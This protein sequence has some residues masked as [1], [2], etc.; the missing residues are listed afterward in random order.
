MHDVRDIVVLARD[1]AMSTTYKPALLRAIV[2]LQRDAGRLELGLVEVAEQFAHLYWTQTVVFHL[3]QAASLSKEPEVLQALRTSAAQTNSHKF[4]ELPTVARERLILS[5][6]RTLRID[7][8]R[9]FHVGLPSGA[10]PI[11]TW[12]GGD[13]IIFTP[14][15][16]DFV[17]A[18]AM[19]LD[20][21]ANHWWARFLEKVNL[22]APAI[23]Q[24]IEAD[25]VRRGSLRWFF[26]RVAQTDNSRCFYC[27]ADLSNTTAVRH[28]DHVLPWSFLLA[29]PAWDLVLACGRCNLGKS[30]RLPNRRFINLLET[31]NRQRVAR[32][33]EFMRGSPPLPTGGISQLY[34]AARA[35]EWP[36]AWEPALL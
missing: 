12:D 35:V 21:I 17:R 13:T 32:M 22:M 24:K 9:R 7:V 30:D 11:Y 26:E 27:N 20:I 19:A 16:V 34:D 25:G 8:L 28:I 10:L 2:R 29:D 18:N 3:R 1:A 14:A 5:I 6:A 15:S 33:P 36:N 4:S 23:I 31:I